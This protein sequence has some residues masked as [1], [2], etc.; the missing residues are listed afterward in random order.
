MSTPIDEKPKFLR[1]LSTLDAT[2]VVVGSMIGSGIFIAPSLMAGYIQ[3]P[4]LLI[5]LW[6]V[7]GVL[8]L[9]G[10]LS[11]GE[12]AAAFPHAGGQYVY[13]KESYS[14]L[15]GFLYGWTLFLIIITGF[16]SAIAIAF[17]KYLGVFFPVL[18][19]QTKILSLPIF[20]KTFSI[21]TAQLISILCIAL[22]TYINI[23]GVKS[24]VLVQN[25]FTISKVGALAILIGAAFLF[26][27][28]TFKNYLPLVKP[29]LG[30][31]AI[32]MSLFAAMAVAMSKALFA[33][34][35]WYTVTFIAEEV[36]NPKKNIPRSMFL[37]TGI[38][39]LLYT[40]AT[41]AFLFMVPIAQMAAVPEN[42]I[43]ATVAQSVMGQAGLI[44]ITV[45]ILISTFGCINGNIL[46]GPRLYYAMAKDGLFF[47][48]CAL[49]HEKRKTPHL[50]LVYQGVWS[51]VLVFTGTYNDLLTYAAFA[52]L[53]FN[54]LTIIGLI[55]LRKT[56][57]DLER[58]YKAW[59]YPV[60][61][62]L[63]VAIAVFFIIYIVIGDPLNS[64]KG[65][66]LILA[67][68]PIYFYWR[69]KSRRAAAIK[70]QN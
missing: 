63:Y 19:E 20:G 62:M 1:S 16:I 14:P 21:S 26:G 55:K 18:G 17:A 36:R 31:L 39:T 41:M 11:Y 67:G 23:R 44:F 6:I 52:S 65:L 37:G 15:W 53:L 29:A 59:G 57:P 32:K 54:A 28:G 30:P 7:G 34:D 48:S 22:L 8:T 25:I 40:T 49:V 2:N 13:L 50:S 66:V 47:K 70:S 58:P 51:C 9:F 33:Y 35:A 3:T 10:A 69:S 56:R 43:A 42:R 12:L 4:G 24:G 45:G 38:T 64:G 68:L 46:T 61:P 5:L 27:N 60:V